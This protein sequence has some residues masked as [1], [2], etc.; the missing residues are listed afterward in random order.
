VPEAEKL[1]GRRTAPAPPF[2]GATHDAAP[3]GG[4]QHAQPE[5]CSAEDAKDRDAKD[6]LAAKANAA[7]EGERRVMDR[8]EINQV[9]RSESRQVVSE[10]LSISKPFRK[11]PAIDLLVATARRDFVAISPRND[12]AE[13]ALSRPMIGPCTRPR[14]PPASPSADGPARTETWEWTRADELAQ[15]AQELDARDVALLEQDITEWRVQLSEVGQ[16]RAELQQ[17]LAESG[18]SLE[19]HGTLHRALLALDMSKQRLIWNI[20]ESEQE[21]RARRRPRASAATDNADPVT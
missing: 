14:L 2:D 15:I 16:Q 7:Q 19:G 10:S 18:E 21:L 13:G 6:R 8:M 20:R 3:E 5:P 17:Q 11:V 1:I 12:R 9:L 4:A